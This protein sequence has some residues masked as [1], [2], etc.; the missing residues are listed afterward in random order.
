MWKD[1]PLVSCPLGAVWPSVGD[2]FV[3]VGGGGGWCVVGSGGRGIVG[4]A[5]SDACSGRGGSAARGMIR[6]YGAANRSLAAPR[7][8]PIARSD[9][10]YVPSIGLTTKKHRVGCPTS[11][12][13]PADLTP[14]RR[15][16]WSPGSVAFVDLRHRQ[17]RELR[18]R[19]SAN[20]R[21]GG[22]QG[23]GRPYGNLAK[24]G[25][26]RGSGRLGPRIRRFCHPSAIRFGAG[27]QAGEWTSG[28]RSDM[29]QM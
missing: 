13:R 19:C 3:S 23:Q 25:R 11:A 14:K 6:R 24:C 9:A 7:S 21:A 4:W 2:E 1:R 28:A 15:A 17:L 20:L 8:G 18:A 26:L 10:M 12:W 29:I 22:G 16:T 5:G 27:F